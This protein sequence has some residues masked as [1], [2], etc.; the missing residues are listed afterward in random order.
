[1]S[2]S[3]IDFGSVNENRYQSLRGDFDAAYRN[4][5]DSSREFN[6]VLMTV[7]AGLSPEERQARK[8]AAA[9]VYEE[10]HERFMVAVAALN[11]FMVAQIVASRGRMQPPASQC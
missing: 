1:M 4:M 6:A 11:Q 8:D 5:R 3:A 9:Q 2:A 10:A 7:P